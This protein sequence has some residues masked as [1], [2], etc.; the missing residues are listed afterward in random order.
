MSSALFEGSYLGDGSRL[1]PDARLECGVCW[2]VYDPAIGDPVWQIPPGTPF[3]DLPD[4]WACPDC[5]SSKTR[6]MVVDDPT[7]TT[8]PDPLAAATRLLDGYRAVEERM[9][10]LPIHNPRLTVDTLGFRR[11]G[12]GVAGV[13]ITP[14]MMSIVH[15]PDVPLARPG[16]SL[17]RA[18]PSG[19]F[20]FV[21]GD[22][23]G[24]GAVETC[25]LFSPMDEFVDME[26]ARLAAEAAV[27][28]LFAAPEP[29]VPAPV[30]PT[31][32]DRR[33]LLFGRGAA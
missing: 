26:A 8:E 12:A 15:I 4:H 28:G 24:F 22:L 21:A 31:P 20:P 14:W 2:H 5:A 10:G 7:A 33:G 6:F 32:V 27:D 18:F 1:A 23:P 30:T 16:D 3:A 29:A 17:D 13:V 25:S 9:A 11:I 19:V